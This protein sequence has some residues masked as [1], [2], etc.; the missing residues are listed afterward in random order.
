VL[1]ISVWE[2]RVRFDLEFE[3]EK[4][5]FAGHGLIRRADPDEGLLGAEISNLD[6]SCR[7]WAIDLMTEN[8]GSGYIPGTLQSASQKSRLR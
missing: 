7:E 5:S 4:V 1:Y 3:G 6:E 8:A 2:E